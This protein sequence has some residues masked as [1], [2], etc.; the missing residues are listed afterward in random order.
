[1]PWL[2]SKKSKATGE[3]VATSRFNRRVLLVGIQVA[4][5]LSLLIA[6]I[7]AVALTSQ[8]SKSTVSTPTDEETYEILQSS[9]SP[10]STPAGEPSPPADSSSPQNGVQ[11]DAKT[12]KIFDDMAA[13]VAAMDAKNA[14][15]RSFTDRSNAISNQ[16]NNLPPIDYGLNPTQ[17]QID[18]LNAEREALRN[19]L[20]A[21]ITDL[22]NQET[23]YERS[24]GVVPSSGNSGCWQGS[25][26][27]PQ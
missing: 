2:F 23:A 1:M 12:Q 27:V 10:V 13:C 11:R 17:E 21:Q 8:N 14:V 18:A 5:L 16:L 6:G 4:V 25:G 9:T 24:F 7:S 3:G 22:Y 19:S 26:P 20:Q 15:I